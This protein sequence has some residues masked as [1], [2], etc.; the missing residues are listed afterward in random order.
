MYPRMDRCA[1]GRCALRGLDHMPR[2]PR[3][4]DKTRDHVGTIGTEGPGSLRILRDPISD[5][6]GFPKSQAD[7][8]TSG[9][10]A[11]YWE[12]LEKLLA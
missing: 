8:L 12:A 1:F 6:S 5:P 10:K 4:S 3:G 2:N 11:H 9:W 7:D